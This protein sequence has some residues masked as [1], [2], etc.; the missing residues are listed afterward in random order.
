MID[1]KKNAKV[2]NEAVTEF[3]HSFLS[4]ASKIKGFVPKQKNDVA[5][6]I[7]ILADGYC[8]AC[9][10][11]DEAKRNEYASA[12]MIR[13][14][15]MIPYLYNKF[16]VLPTLAPE[17]VV[18]W[19]WDSIARACKYRGWTKD[20][21]KVKGKVDGAE[22]CINQCITTTAAMACKFASTNSRKVALHTV[23]MSDIALPSGKEPEICS[24]DYSDGKDSSGAYCKA[25]IGKIASRSVFDGMVADAIAFGDCFKK[26]DSGKYDFDERSLV[27][28]IRKVAGSADRI[29]SFSKF[30]GIPKEDVERESTSIMEMSSRAIHKAIDGAKERIFENDEVYFGLCC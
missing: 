4:E 15:H 12:L 19:I 3:Y 10:E 2:M 17:D 13:Y 23:T 22:K 18:G 30:Y 27:S 5:Y 11:R 1:C 24:D 9:D 28:S 21:N 26:D 16:K 20:G 6:D 25:L 7:G 14:W 29:A 8:R